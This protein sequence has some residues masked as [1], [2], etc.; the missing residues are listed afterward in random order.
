MDRRTKYTQNIIKET[1]IDLLSEKDITKITVS[2]ICEIADIN[3]AT[4]YRYYIDVYDLLEKIEMNFSEELKD[5]YNAENI[6]EYTVA[7]FSKALLKAFVE[8][9]KL[10]KILFNNKSTTNFLDD[11]LEIVYQTCKDKWEQ[12]LPGISQEDIEYAS[13]FLFNGA[14]GVINFWIKNDFDKDIEEIARIIE[15]LAYYGLKKYI[16]HY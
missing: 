4:F 15:Q 13:V 3:R 10:V 9:K 12:E 8:N 2:E 6:T 1:F 11:I 16:Y 5:A 7:N 14:L